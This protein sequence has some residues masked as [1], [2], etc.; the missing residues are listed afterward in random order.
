ME[1]APH[2]AGF[3]LARGALPNEASPQ[4]LPRGG[5]KIDSE[6]AVRLSRRVAEPADDLA[7]IGGE[8]AVSADPEPQPPGEPPA[9]WVDRELWMKHAKRELDE[10]IREVESTAPKRRTIDQDRALLEAR[11][12][13]L[14]LDSTP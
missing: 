9:D 11:R 2:I 14:R 12:D 1:K 3:S 7:A 4:Y 6:T 10:L 5:A 13:A 8:L